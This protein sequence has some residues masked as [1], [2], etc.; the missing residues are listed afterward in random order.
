MGIGNNLQNGTNNNFKIPSI[1]WRL[2][3]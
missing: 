3:K 2:Y 1:Y